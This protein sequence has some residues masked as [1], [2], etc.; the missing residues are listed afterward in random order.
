MQDCNPPKFLE[1]NHICV[2][3]TI[4]YARTSKQIGHTIRKGAQQLMLAMVELGLA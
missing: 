3:Y 2:H 1:P 4:I